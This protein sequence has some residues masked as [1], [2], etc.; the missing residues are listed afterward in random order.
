MATLEADL[1]DLQ[2]RFSE[3]VLGRE[4]FEAHARELL[5]L[6]RAQCDATESHNIAMKD[7]QNK[8]KFCYRAITHYLSSEQKEE[9][10][11][12]QSDD[13]DDEA[14]LVT[15]NLP[16]VPLCSFVDYDYAL[17][18]SNPHRTD[19][20]NVGAQSVSDKSKSS[21]KSILSKYGA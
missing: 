11:K 14:P 17:V 13:S 15:K 16:A 6:W 9:A 19:V 21:R 5:A 10:F 3:E 4:G 2:A 7:V 12:V 18:D 8:A 1:D 20:N